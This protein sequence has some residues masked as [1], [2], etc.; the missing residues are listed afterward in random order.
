MTI[1]DDEN[2]SSLESSCVKNCDFEFCSPYSLLLL[3][4]VSVYLRLLYSRIVKRYFGEFFRENFIEPLSM[5]LAKIF[6]RR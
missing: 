6:T 4:S 5:L 3:L 1:F 2:F